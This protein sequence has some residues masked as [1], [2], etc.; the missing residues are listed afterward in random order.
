VGLTRIYLAIYSFSPV[1]SP[2]LAYPWDNFG[3]LPALKG[4]V[5]VTQTLTNQSDEM[6]TGVAA[7]WNAEGNQN[8]ENW[9]QYAVSSSVSY[10]GQFSVGVSPI[11]STSATPTSTTA[12]YSWQPPSHW[13]VDPQQAQTQPYGQ[14]QQ[15]QSQRPALPAYSKK[16]PKER[17]R[18]KEEEEIIAETAAR[19]VAVDRVPL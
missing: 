11:A 16:L 15:Q 18:T 19:F 14:V 10:N 9:S 3:H 12:A 1:K 7:T 6:S 2:Y 17:G 4:K 13:K 8:A 5:P